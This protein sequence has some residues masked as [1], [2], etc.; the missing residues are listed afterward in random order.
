MPTQAF[1]PCSLKIGE[2]REFFQCRNAL[3]SNL[4]VQLFVYTPLDLR[5]QHEAKNQNYYLAVCLLHELSLG[6]SCEVSELSHRIGA[7][8]T[9][10]SG[11]LTEVPWL[12]YSVQAYITARASRN[13]SVAPSFS[14][15]RDA[16]ESSYPSGRFIYF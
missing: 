12:E 3:L 7:G 14:I 1:P 9:G 5:V 4:M 6:G 11:R 13:A 8:Y 2:R 10:R 16:T 15:I